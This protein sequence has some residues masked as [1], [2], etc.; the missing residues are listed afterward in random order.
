[1]LRMCLDFCG[2][3]NVGFKV[4]YVVR[5]AS[6]VILSSCTTAYSWLISRH[7]LGTMQ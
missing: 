5:P 1:M 6:H 2:C 4:S 7:C 3:S